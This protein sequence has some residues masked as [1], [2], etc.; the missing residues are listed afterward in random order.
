MVVL[1]KHGNVYIE[2]WNDGNIYR[3]YRHKGQFLGKKELVKTKEE[4]EKE[5]IEKKKIITI[6]KPERYHKYQF[7]IQT[8]YISKRP[9]HSRFG[10]IT[11][12]IYSEEELEEEDIIKRAIELVT[13]LD[14]WIDYVPPNRKT[15]IFI[16]HQIVNYR[17][18]D[19]ARFRD[20]GSA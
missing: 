1:E 12:E 16:D 20:L 8:D 18:D 4:R 9:N 2:L 7:A 15:I 10:E 5:E 13:G 14:Y 11:G 17:Y 6:G 19:Y 3:V